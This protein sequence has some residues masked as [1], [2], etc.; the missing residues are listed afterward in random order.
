MR[1]TNAVP[2]AQRV[3]QAARRPDGLASDVDRSDAFVQAAELYRRA[4]HLGEALRC[5]EESLAGIDD[6]TRIYPRALRARLLIE[7]G[8]TAEGW[9]AL[10]E[11]R[12]LMRESFEASTVVPETLEA[13]GAPDTAVRWL[14]DAIA[15]L[16][17]HTDPLDAK[18]LEGMVDHR[19][20]LRTTFGIRP[21]GADD[22]EDTGE[23]QPISLTDAY[24][25]RVDSVSEPADL[26]ASSPTGPHHIAVLYWPRP[27]FDAFAAKWPSL[28]EGYGGTWEGHRAEVAATLATYRS[29]RS[30][31]VVVV[32]ARFDDFLAY[33]ADNGLDPTG[34]GARSGYALTL[35]R[36]GEGV[37]WPPDRNAQCWCGSGMRYKKCCRDASR[38]SNAYL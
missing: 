31:R 15:E 6:T 18:L 35:G 2:A 33:A 24:E 1:A 17:G 37:A 22:F 34:P 19:H 30:A 5:V 23:L 3:A 9:A 12:P 29:T 38:Q 25:V 4:D 21:D 28:A 26:S 13:I 20:R 7:N 11:L 8:R 27:E 16:N 36:A 32:S 14:T 10:D